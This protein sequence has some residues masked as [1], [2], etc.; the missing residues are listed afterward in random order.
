MRGVGPGINSHKNAEKYDSEMPGAG[1]NQKRKQKVLSP[2]RGKSLRWVTQATVKIAEFGCLRILR[3]DG[4]DEK[5]GLDWPPK[6]V[7]MCGRGGRIRTCDLSVPNRAHYQAV[8]RP[9]IID[10]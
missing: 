5:S 4:A 6:R 8:L 3:R 10:E 9:A 2:I 7:E 1:K